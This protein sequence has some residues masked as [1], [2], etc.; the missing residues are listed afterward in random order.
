MA[1]VTATTASAACWKLFPNA[2]PHK[3]VRKPDQTPVTVTL[4]LSS[5]REASETLLAAYGLITLYREM[6]GPGAER[7]A[8][9]EIAGQMLRLSRWFGRMVDDAVAEE[10]AG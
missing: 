5:A 2:M 10:K 4:R 3:H 6:V 7:D 1:A 8:A 9:W